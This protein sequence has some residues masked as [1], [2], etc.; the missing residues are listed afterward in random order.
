MLFTATN[1]LEK[2]KQNPMFLRL[3][4]KW[5]LSERAKFYG[6]AKYKC[7]PKFLFQKSRYPSKGLIFNFSSVWSKPLRVIAYFL[8]FWYLSS[9]KVCLHQ[10]QVMWSETFQDLLWV[11]Q[12]LPIGSIL[13]GHGEIP[14]DWKSLV[15]MRKCRFKFE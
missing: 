4:S 11:K 3:G 14:K 9:A 1:F 12:T 7:S 6:K 8:L 13:L 15:Y 2:Q 5:A 10:F